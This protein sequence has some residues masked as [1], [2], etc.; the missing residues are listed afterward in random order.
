MSK[1][2]QS[3]LLLRRGFDRASALL[4]QKEME[5]RTQGP[6]LARGE[7]GVVLAQLL[8]E[9]TTPPRAALRLE[10]FDS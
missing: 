6:R 5:G 10:A 7:M 3:G 9:K 8:C 1:V 2:C 4:Q